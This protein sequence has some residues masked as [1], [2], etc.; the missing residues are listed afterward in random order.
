M[1][2]DF[3]STSVST[4]DEQ[5]TTNHQPRTGDAHLVWCRA[6]LWQHGHDLGARLSDRSVPMS[7]TLT[8]KQ[9]AT[10]LTASPEADDVRAA[11]IAQVMERLPAAPTDGDVCT[12]ISSTFA[13]TAPPLA[14]FGNS[15]PRVARVRE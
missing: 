2:P 15:A 7:A 1:R 9:M 5:Q 12:A 13:S 11:F 6:D 14:S 4:E 8:F 3:R 10:I